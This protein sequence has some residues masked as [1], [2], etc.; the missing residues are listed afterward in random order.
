MQQKGQAVREQDMLKTQWAQ[1]IEA[2]K[3]QE[4]QKFILNRERNLELIAHNAAEKELRG[5]QVHH[6]KQRDK[7]LLEAALTHQAALIEIEDA[8]KLK[9]RQEVIELQKY[10]KQSEADKGAYQ[11]LVDEFVEAEAERQ[12]KMRE[13]QWQR[14]EQARI[15][16]LKDVYHSRE[17]DVLLKQQKKQEMDWLRNHERE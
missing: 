4:R 3:E 9:R 12:Y 10:Y 2:D 6:E 16:L 5:T 13:A 15:N 8:E 11:K 1:E 7:D 14:E 17:K